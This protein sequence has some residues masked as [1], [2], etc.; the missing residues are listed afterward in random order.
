MVSVLNLPTPTPAPTPEPYQ[1]ESDAQ[2]GEPISATDSLIY[3]F[4]KDYCPY[5]QQLDPLTRALP[6]EITLPDGTASAVKL[7]CIN[8]NTDDGLALIQQYYDANDVIEDRQFVPAMVIGERYMM[9]GNEIID[10][11]LTALLSGEGLDTP[12]IDGG[13]RT[14]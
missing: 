9:P 5:C 2:L 7:V 14:E 13:E 3:Y 6:D 10:Q 1:P 11:L 8:K 4:Y 12:L